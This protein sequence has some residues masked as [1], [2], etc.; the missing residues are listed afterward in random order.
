MALILAVKNKNTE[1][2]EL[3]HN[4]TIVVDGNNRYGAPFATA[5]EP[6]LK[7]LERCVTTALN[8]LYGSNEELIN[9]FLNSN[10]VS[11]DD[12][13]LNYGT[14]TI[15]NYA[16]VD[17][18]NRL[19]KMAEDNLNKILGGKSIEEYEQEYNNAYN[20]AYGEQNGMRLAEAFV[21]SQYKGV[22]RIKT[23][24]QAVGILAMIA[25][26]VIPVGG[27]AASALIYGGMATATAGGT[28]VQFGEA[29]TQK[30]GITEEDKRAIVQE[31]ATSAALMATGAGIGKVSSLA[32]A[33]L[34]MA[35]CPRLM[36]LSA[37]IGTDAT[38]SILADY[39]I[40]GQVDLT[41]E[42]ISQ[43]IPV[44]AGVLK[45][46]GSIQKSVD[47]KF[48]QRVPYNAQ[49]YLTEAPEKLTDLTKTLQS[50]KAPLGHIA[51]LG[52]PKWQAL[53]QSIETPPT[54]ATKE[55]MMYYKYDS[56]DINSLLSSFKNRE[57]IIDK[58]IIDNI[59]ELNTYIKNI[60]DYINTQ[61]LKE[62]I[63]VY[64]DDSDFLLTRIKLV[65]GNTLA[66]ELKK[67]DSVKDSSLASKLA[68]ELSE[69][70]FNASVVQERFMSTTLVKE[71][72][73]DKKKNIR[74]EF[75][76]PKGTKGTFIETYNILNRH[77]NQVE[78]LLQRDSKIIIKNIERIGYKWHI[79]A[80]II[81]E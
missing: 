42:G 56:W 29:I 54:G 43:L 35:N 57:I 11:F 25:G 5:I 26:Q 74:W 13:K 64:R 1:L 70:I 59:D 55:A 41:S 44:I 39:A 9:E 10:G 77:G 62:P 33:E 24:V 3:L 67:I 18:S 65:N 19:Q 36:A 80:D 16:L 61:V 45:T 76:V 27:Q 40:T 17:I 78:Y 34:V 63:V 14:Y 66:E 69:Q 2:E 4:P 68:K 31:L 79:K 32:Y 6:C 52:Q 21:E 50:N 53:I 12:G 75:N 8:K 23:G 49:T 30:G 48:L 73:F 22:Q 28:A 58:K 37:K 38:L 15:R 81:Q 46:K 51:R 60:T 47:A 72:H 71:L 7:N 20:L